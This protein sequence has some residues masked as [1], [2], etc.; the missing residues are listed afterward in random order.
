MEWKKGGG[1]GK[2]K[3]RRTCELE[4]NWGDEGIQVGDWGWKGKEEI[5]DR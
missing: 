5:G 1:W 4:L 2:K 3:K